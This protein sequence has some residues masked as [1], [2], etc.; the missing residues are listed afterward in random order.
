MKKTTKI[1]FSILACFVFALSPLLFVGCGNSTL[2]KDE[3][4]TIVEIAAN[5]FLPS[6]RDV[7]NFKDITY[8]YQRFTQNT[9]KET[10]H[11]KENAT[12]TQYVDK[13]FTNKNEVSKAIDIAIKKDGNI[14]IAEI[15]INTITGGVEYSVNVDGTLKK[16]FPSIQ[17]QE[18]YRIFS[19]VDDADTKYAITYTSAENGA[20]PDVKTYATKTEANYNAYILEELLNYT[21]E[22]IIGQFFGVQEM[23]LFYD[24]VINVEKDGKGT[25]V[26]LAVE[27]PAVNGETFECGKLSVKEALYFNKNNKIDSAESHNITKYE[28]TSHRDDRNFWYENRAVVNTT[29]S[30]NGYILDSD[31]WGN[32]A[33]FLQ[34]LP[35]AEIQF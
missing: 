22:K 28:T 1:L 33:T 27:M 15:T 13:T 26:S 31:V 18:T 3:F 29:T 25:K 12:D 21:N 32:C 16:F 7:E 8:H 5:D 4:N 11:Y 6:H 9:T 35:A 19:Y 10:L 24:N 23:L 14:L 17:Q 34:Q 30:L 20:E 2:S